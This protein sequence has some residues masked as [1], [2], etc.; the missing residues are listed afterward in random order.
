MCVKRFP[1]NTV[2]SLLHG[3]LFLESD[4]ALTELVVTTIHLSSQ[5]NHRF[6]DE[7]GVLRD[8]II[9]LRDVCVDW[10][11][12]YDKRVNANCSMSHLRCLLSQCFLVK[13]KLSIVPLC[14]LL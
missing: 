11:I 10:Q 2:E 1:S 9:D 4:L 12:F 8:E 7:Q 6:C 14:D 5:F 3:C 13:V